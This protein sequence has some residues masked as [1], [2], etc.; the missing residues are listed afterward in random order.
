MNELFRTPVNILKN[1][2]PILHHNQIAMVGSCFSGNIYKKLKLYRFNCFS[3]PTGILYNPLSIISMLNRL[4]QKK[5]YSKEE[6]FFHNGLWKSFDH[7]SAFSDPEPQKCISAINASF[8]HAVT[9]IEKL[10]V[11]ILTFGSAFVYER[12]E[13]K[14]IVANC[15]KIPECKFIRRLASISEIESACSQVF[16]AFLEKNPLLNII[17]TLSPVRHLGDCPHENSVSKAHCLSAINSL[18][19]KF[20]TVYY[21]PAFELMI[22]ELRDYRFYAS[23]M[24]HPSD[25]AI[26][27]IWKRFCL[28][29]IDKNGKEFIKRYSNIIAARSHKISFSDT[30]KSIE[31]AAA[32][33]KYLDILKKEYQHIDFADDYVHFKSIVS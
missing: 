12:L 23:D 3:N 13:D 27:F 28:A 29:C 7:H 22:D 26:E 33:I 20:E 18:T 11:L 9:A 14:K 31:F 1:K 10:D 4:L 21:F 15:H 16:N 6:L 30:E 17:L 8:L 25:T 19:K 2:R 24:I 32:Q 5:I